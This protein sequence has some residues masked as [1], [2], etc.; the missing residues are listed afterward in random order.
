MV[1]YLQH[2]GFGIFDAIQDS[3]QSAYVGENFQLRTLPTQAGGYSKV[4]H[5]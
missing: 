4:T 2:T 5:R 3:G 1:D